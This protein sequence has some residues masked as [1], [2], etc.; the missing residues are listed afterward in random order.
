M[1]LER[2]ESL[3]KDWRRRYVKDLR[4]L[5][6]LVVGLDE[7]PAELEELPLELSAILHQSLRQRTPLR[8]HPTDDGPSA[9]ADAAEQSFCRSSSL[10]APSPREQF[11]DPQTL[12][13]L[14]EVCKQ[15]SKLESER[16]RAPR[17]SAESEKG[18]S[19]ASAAENTPILHS[20]KRYQNPITN[21]KNDKERL[22]NNNLKEEP[23]SRRDDSSVCL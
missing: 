23:L 19:A 6:K 17:V 14:F 2:L 4:R 13:A 11:R 18:P 8:V 20:D 22:S 5:R 16:L 3:Y 10:E 1:R 12:A 7:L 15:K 9:A 21:D